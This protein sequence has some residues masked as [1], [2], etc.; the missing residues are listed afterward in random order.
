MSPD[1]HTSVFK[2]FYDLLPKSS[3]VLVLLRTGAESGSHILSASSTMPHRGEKVRM[4]CML[5]E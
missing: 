4:R 5:G 1:Y 3:E 2:N